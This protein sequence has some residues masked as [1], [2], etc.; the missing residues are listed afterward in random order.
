M[1]K[2]LNYIILKKKICF[3][4]FLLFEGYCYENVGVFV[5]NICG[6]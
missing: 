6:L 4:Y 1:N 2:Y 5:Y 3:I